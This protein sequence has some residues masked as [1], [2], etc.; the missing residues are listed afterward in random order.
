M[1]KLDNNQNIGSLSGGAE[2]GIIDLGAAGLVVGVGG[3]SGTFSGKITNSGSFTKDGTGTLTLTGDSDYTG[4]TVL[5]AGTLNVNSATAIGIGSLTISGGI[6]GNTSGESVELSTDMPQSWTGGFTFA[7][8]DNLDLGAGDVTLGAN[9]TVT[10]NSGTLLVGGA[11][12][13]SSIDESPDSCSLTKAGFGTLTLSGDNDYDGGTTLSAGTL[14]LNGPKAIGNGSLTISGGILGNTSGSAVE[15][16]TDMPQCWAAGFTFAGPDNLDL[17][18]GDVTLGA[19]CTVTVNS[20]TLTVGGEIDEDT[21]SYGLTKAGS[22]TLTLSAA[23][24]YDGNTTIS[25]GTLRLGA[26]G[27]IPY[28]IGTSKGNVV[29]NGGATAGTLDLNGFDATI[30]GLSGGTGAVLGQVINSAAGTKT[31]TVGGNGATTTYAGL[32]KDNNGAGGTLALVKTGS[33]TLTLSGPSTYTGGTTIQAGAL[34]AQNNTA[35]GSGSVTVANGSALQVQGGISLGN[36]LSLTGTGASGALENISGANT[37][38]G[39]VSLAGNSTI[40]SDAGTLDL[41]NSITGSGTAL[42][43]AGSGGGTITG[44]IETGAG[45]LTKGGTGTWN[46]CGANTYTGGTTINGGMLAIGSEGTLGVAPG[47]GTTNLTFAGNG[48]LQANSDLVLN[49]YWQ[50]N[51]ASGVTATIDTQAGSV[52]IAGAVTGSGGLTKLGNGTLT[53][54]AANSY[55]GGTTL[56]AGT[57]NVNSAS[58]IGTGPLT[59]NGGALGNTSESTVTLSNNQTWNGDFAFAGPADLDLGNSSVTLNGNRTVSVSSGKLT[60]GGVIDDGAN[61]YGLAKSGAGTL[62]LSGINT[63][64]G[65]TTISG[66][67]LS[68]SAD[69]NLGSGGELTFDG[70]TLRITASG[71]QFLSGRAVAINAPGGTIDVTNAAATATLSSV[72]TGEGELTKTGPGMLTLTADSLYTGDTR[73]EGGTLNITGSLMSFV[74]VCEFGQVI[75]SGAP[76]WWLLALIGPHPGEADYITQ[77]YLTLNSAPVWAAGWQ[78]AVR[79]AVSG[80]AYVTN[81][82]QTYT[83]PSG[84]FDIGTVGQ[85]D[86]RYQL[87]DLDQSQFG[88]NSNSKLIVLEDKTGVSGNDYDYDDFFWQVADLS[89]SL[90]CC[91]CVCSCDCPVDT[92]S[93]LE[94]L[95]GLLWKGLKGAAGLVY[96][97]LWNPHPVVE[98]DYTIP[99]KRVNGNWTTPVRLEAQ[100]T[101]NGV[102]GDTFYYSTQG[103]TCGDKV[104]MALQANTTLP[105][106][107]YDYTVA[108][109]AYFQDNPTPRTTYYSS[110][111]EIVNRA[112]SP[113]GNRW[114]LIGLDQLVAGDPGNGMTLVRGDGTAAWFADDGRGEYCPA[115]GRFSSLKHNG[116]GYRLEYP[117]GSRDEFDSTGLLVHRYDRL[118]NVTHYDYTVEEGEK[119]LRITDPLDRETTYRYTG[120]LITSITDRSITDKVVRVTTLH[121]DGNGRL[122][123]VTLPDPDGDAPEEESPVW[124]FGYD[125][126]GRMTSVTNPNQTDPNQTNATISY[127]YDSAGL[128]IKETYPNGADRHLESVNG[129]LLKLLV[130]NSVGS[131]APLVLSTDVKATRTDQLDKVTTYTTDRFGYITSK[132]VSVDSQL[133]KTTYTRDAN[134]LVTQVEEPDPDGNLGP[135]GQIVTN[136]TYDS[137]GNLLSITHAFDTPD[138]ATE[139]WTYNSTYS[140]PTRYTDELGRVT[141][142]DFNPTTK[143]IDSMT[144]VVHLDDGTRIR[145]TPNSTPTW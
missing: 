56:S 115:P 49:A 131:P 5:H 111:G 134:G 70:G 3:G 32:L 114:S 31:L 7:G 72:I 84:A 1:L 106:R 141:K 2:G 24:S 39:A 116:D 48:T 89:Y 82:H 57:L 143:L 36:A 63:Y 93:G 124:H 75:G 17:G 73:V 135:L 65:D 96:G 64:N 69:N 139:S 6:L 71:S 37:L 94:D 145:A 113:F 58:A 88:L 123:S 52:T 95:G 16:S 97:S 121:H 129:S 67:V 43:L 80:Y 18:D 51:I 102:T 23:N 20:G 4:S 29:L 41:T 119:V 117:D 83:F 142:Y 30:N 42:V 107:H 46:L 14:N 53:L 133:L 126:S 8:P 120:D 101:F 144:Q 9:C 78:A 22:G 11:I 132:T 10:V 44:D 55:G 66:G 85:L 77:S 34:K 136:Y 12:D 99:T 103:T 15:L 62:T 50:V 118:D 112:S 40:F 98:F 130:G 109:R 25:A 33:G 61:S 140:I 87:F 79:K 13:E 100:L 104:R 60:V 68:V 35:L 19:N 125:A 91:Y 86:A 122:E 128:L 45:S 59:V 38:T 27:A 76:R 137:R 108:V 127:E 105:S 92:A 28:E 26:A 90:N 110:S 21:G 47:P 54:S 81:S 138:Q 74:I